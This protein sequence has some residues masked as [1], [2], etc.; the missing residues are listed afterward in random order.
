MCGSKKYEK[1]GNK[2]YYTTE[3]TI[4]CVLQQILE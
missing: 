4:I 2:E 3:K 1:K